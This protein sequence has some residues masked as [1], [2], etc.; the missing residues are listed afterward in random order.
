[1]G[2]N[3]AGASKPEDSDRPTLKGARVRMRRPRGR[4][5]GVYGP[6]GHRVTQDL[7]AAASWDNTEL[8]PEQKREIHNKGVAMARRALVLAKERRA[9]GLVDGNQ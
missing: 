7:D 6:D 5:S 4:G 1:M 3:R 9:A 8:T 2:W